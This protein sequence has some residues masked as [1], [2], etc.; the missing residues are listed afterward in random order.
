MRQWRFV[1]MS[2]DGECTAQE[3][4]GTLSWLEMNRLL[5]H[6]ERNSARAEDATAQLNASIQPCAQP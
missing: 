2:P 1:H 5:A 3:F 6:I 4:P